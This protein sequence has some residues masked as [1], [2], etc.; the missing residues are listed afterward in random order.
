MRERVREALQERSSRI[1]DSKQTHIVLGFD[2]A[3]QLSEKVSTS[4]VTLTASECVCCVCV[5]DG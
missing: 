1:R 2:S 4:F 5:L 3:P